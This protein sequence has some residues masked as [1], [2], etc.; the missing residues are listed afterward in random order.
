ARSRRTGS[1]VRSPGPCHPRPMRGRWPGRR[2]PR[3]CRRPLRR[4][5]AVL[6]W[7]GIASGPPWLARKPKDALRDD[8]A[9]NLVGAGVDRAGHGEQQVIDPSAVRLRPGAPG[10]GL[11][12]QEA[13]RRVVEIEVEFGPE[14]LVDGTLGTDVLTLQEAGDGVP[15]EE[16]V[17]LGTDPGVDNVVHRVG[18]VLTVSRE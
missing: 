5:R 14:D 6:P 18:S 13:E 10:L 3:R 1:T 11:R 9:L 2:G 4:T 8:V 17:G 7:A 16:P 12:A 15:R